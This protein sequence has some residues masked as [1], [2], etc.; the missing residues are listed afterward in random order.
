MKKSGGIIAII[1]G[2]LATFAAIITLFFGAAASVLE[3]LE[4][5]SDVTGGAAG[6]M[7]VAMGWLGLL[8]A[9]AIIVLGAMSMN[10]ENRKPG[11]ALIIVSVVGTV[12]SG[13]LTMWFTIIA[14]LGGILATVGVKPD[15]VKAD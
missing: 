13:G 1:A 14:I 4:E 3:S 7:V 8:A 5:V 12:V 9:I 11:V 6:G 10:A 2:V 15:E